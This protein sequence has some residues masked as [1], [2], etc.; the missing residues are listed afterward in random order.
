ML[1]TKG[2]TF[3]LT[4]VYYEYLIRIVLNHF[5][6]SVLVPGADHSAQFNCNLNEWSH[7]VINFIGPNIGQGYILYIDGMMH[8]RSGY[9]Q[10]TPGVI[11][12]GRIAIG[13]QFI[14]NNKFL[15]YAEFAVDELLFFNRTLT[16]T[17]ISMFAQT[18]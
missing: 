6:Y 10:F 18:T 11:N 1:N 9:S 4:M 3:L 12:N 5:R 16:D 14:E 17:E 2:V 13:R 8:R 15:A 7:S